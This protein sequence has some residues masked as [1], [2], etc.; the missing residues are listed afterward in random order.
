MF[1]ILH[2][3][4]WYQFEVNKKYVRVRADAETTEP[5]TVK[6]LNKEITLQP[7]VWNEIGSSCPFIPFTISNY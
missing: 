4:V 3:D 2:Q 5:T 7:G 1:K 6:V